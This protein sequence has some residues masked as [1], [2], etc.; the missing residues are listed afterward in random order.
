MWA[1]Y[2]DSNFPIVNVKMTG[3][4]E[5]NNDFQNFLDTWNAYNSNL[6]IHDVGLLKSNEFSAKFIFV[7]EV[8]NKRTL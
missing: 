7:I 1:T 2:N 4:P 8:L 5:N 3:V 6:E